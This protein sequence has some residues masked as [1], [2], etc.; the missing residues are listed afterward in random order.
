MRYTWPK[1]GRQI[2]FGYQICI[3]NNWCAFG[4]TENY[5]RLRFMKS[6]LLPFQYYSFG[7][8]VWP[9]FFFLLLLLVLLLLPSMYYIQSVI[10]VN[11]MRHGIVV[12]KHRLF[13]IVIVLYLDE[14]FVWR[15]FE[16]VHFSNIKPDTIN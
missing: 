16:R 10:S 1:H 2:I 15:F 12:C 13:W 4:Y 9:V 3:T 7:Y 8:A 11:S 5:F 6:P 14:Y